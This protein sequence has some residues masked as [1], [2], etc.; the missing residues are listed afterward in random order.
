MI[1]NRWEQRLLW[2]RWAC[3]RRR[4]ASPRQGS[5]PR[6]E[7]SPRTSGG[8][9]QNLLIWVINGVSLYH[10][11]NPKSGHEGNAKNIPGGEEEAKH[12]RHN[13][14]RPWNQQLLSWS[15]FETHNMNVSI[16]VGRTD[17][18]E[19][20]AGC[21]QGQG[22]GCHHQG[23]VWTFCACAWVKSQSD[24]LTKGRSVKAPEMTL[25]MV[26]EMPT[27]EMRKAAELAA[28]PAH[29]IVQVLVLFIKSEYI[30][31]IV[32]CICLCSPLL[33]ASSTR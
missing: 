16:P 31:Y 15:S 19:C 14:K 18:H 5:R 23:A 8:R 32:L 10:Y 2:Q 27:T 1:T 28:T 12:G 17:G 11:R 20:R 25:P 24:H 33:V 26:L 30:K 6:R 9:L 4:W 29:H 7:G 13:D 22:E 21:S 3:Q